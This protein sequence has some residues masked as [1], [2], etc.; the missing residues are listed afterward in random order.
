MSSVKSR[1]FGLA[2]A[3]EFLASAH[4]RIAPARN[5]YNV[6][7]PRAALVALLV[8]SVLDGS[9][10]AQRAVGT[11]HGAGAGRLPVRSG[12]VGHRGLTNRF[13]PHHAHFRHDGFGSVFVPYF[14]PYDE[15][16]EYEPEAVMTPVAMP[17]PEARQ[18]PT[19]EPPIPKAQV[20][21]IPS[22]S[23]TAAKIP[24]PTIFILVNGERLETRRYV[25]TDNNLSVSIDRRQRTIPLDMLDINATIAANKERGI[26]LRIPADRT[27]IFLSF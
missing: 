19:L 16:F 20:I 24:P 8:A 26:D 6:I 17:P 12:F 10:P 7:M 3:A 13:Y 21:E 15:S 4:Y 11:F 27:E 5:G 9:L 22:T 14:A 18:S 25:L 2:N 23:S 1:W